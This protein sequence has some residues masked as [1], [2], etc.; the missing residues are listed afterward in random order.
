[1]AWSQTDSTVIVRDTFERNAQSL[2]DSLAPPESDISKDAIKSK[3]NYT[4]KDTIKYNFETSKI[5]LYGDA[6]VTYE[7]IELR[8]AYIEV[9]MDSNIVFARGVKDSLG[10]LRGK[11]VFKEGS[12][13]FRS[14]SMTYNFH[15]EKG[16][17][18]DVITQEGEGYI[19]GQDVKKTKGDI[20]Y[21]R[22]GAYT[23]CDHDDPH[24][25][26][27]AKKLKIIPDDKIIAK[28]ANLVIEDVPT[29]I[30]VPF[31]IFPNRNRGKSGIVVPVPGESKRD[32]FYLQNLGYY[33]YLN[34]KSELQLEGDVYSKGSF[35]I[36]PTYN[37]KT[38][39]KR[40]GSLNLRYKKTVTGVIKEDPNYSVTKDYWLDWSHR[41][42]AKARPNSTFGANV[43]LGTQTSYRNDINTPDQN[44]LQ[45]NFQSKVS[46]SKYMLQKRLNFSVNARHNQNNSSGVVNFTLP[47]ASLTL[48][49]VYPFK[50]KNSV[51]TSWT[52]KI[53]VSYTGNFRNELTIKNSDL[54]I[55]KWDSIQNNF[56]NGI[57]HIIPVST[58]FKIFKHFTLNPTLNYR[59]NWYFSTSRMV[60]DTIRHYDSTGA[61][62][63]LTDTNYL[64][65]EAG[66]SRM[67]AWDVN[68]NLTTKIYG[69][70]QF[71]NGPIKAF[72][73]ILTPSI[74]VSYTPENKQGIVSYRDTIYDAEDPKKARGE[75]IEYSIYQGQV[76]SAL[77]SS[78]SGRLNFGLLNNFEMKV[79][80]RKD[81]TDGEKKVK[82]LENV[83]L[84]TSYDMIADSLKWSNVTMSGFTNLT[85]N[86]NLQFGGTYDLYALDSI[87]KRAFK[88]NRFEWNENGRLARMTKANLALNL[89]FASKKGGKKKQQKQQQQD[90]N[91]DDDGYSGFN[92]DPNKHGM[93]RDYFG[94][95]WDVPWN[96][97]VNYNINYSKPLYEE[98]ITQS[99]KG[100]GDISLTKNWKFQFE[101]WYDFEKKDISYAR[102]GILR[103]L[104]CWEMKMDWVPIGSRQNYSFKISVRAS[105]L[106]DLKYEKKKF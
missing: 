94:V 31:G 19:H 92:Q 83:R 55:N 27:A 6:V 52:D 41:Q 96:L 49:R 63:P 69:M 105:L 91:G 22:N 88:V 10:V 45:N 2:S 87:A 23:T 33:F 20:V 61:P 59:E 103:N 38:R 66:F 64:V 43:S 72:R 93:R 67:N 26:I 44:Y 86:V 82:L 58:N 56:K 100:N 18:V 34:E 21:I 28:P 106:Q 74:G 80:N 42:D 15:T 57:T 13:E 17:I 71:K 39:Y 32:G 73:H 98:T 47:E 4:A 14:R 40:S 62:L 85:K 50:T 1:M 70:V 65:K 11:P 51:G 90:D 48:T 89:R 8:A 9:R 104:H 36:R 30:V 76:Y 101:S 35:A 25:E 7:D 5:Y 84:G 53:G 99:L 54:A 79:R 60:W 102:V 77:N 68:A 75:Y 81:S 95:N 97:T 24:F 16:K 78:E 12:Q 46:Y 29:P 37:Y 3:V